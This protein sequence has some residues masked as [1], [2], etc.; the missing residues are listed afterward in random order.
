M[1]IR[2]S[3]K[4]DVGAWKDIH[5]V[6]LHDEGDMSL[7]T[8]PRTTDAETFDAMKVLDEAVQIW[9]DDHAHIRREFGTAWRR[10]SIRGS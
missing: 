7:T 2:I 3:I 10:A 1:N 5:F 9:L 6:T 4:T 8:P